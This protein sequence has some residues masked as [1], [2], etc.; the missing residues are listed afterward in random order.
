MEAT[1]DAGTAGAESEPAQ[2]APF[3]RGFG[4][5]VRKI[6]NGP[7]RVPRNRTIRLARVTCV[8]GGCEITKAQVRVRVRKRLF[9]GQARYPDRILGE[10]ELAVVRIVVP[11]RA[12]RTI[13]RRGARI[14]SLF[15]RVD[16]EEGSRLTRAVRIGLRR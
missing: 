11:P 9:N 8:S 2:V 14:A 7:V 16:A 5:K 3:I 12:Y 6:G 1:N 13:G 10:G 15:L 4:I